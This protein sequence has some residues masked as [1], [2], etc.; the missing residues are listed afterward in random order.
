MIT[1]KVCSDIG[2]R[3]WSHNVKSEDNWYNQPAIQ[4]IRSISKHHFQNGFFF[5]VRGL[6]PVS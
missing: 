1:I 2:P 4:P 3:S 5:L 6:P